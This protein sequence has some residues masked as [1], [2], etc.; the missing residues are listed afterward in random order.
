MVVS[1][2][3]CIRANN[4][5]SQPMTDI[6]AGTRIFASWSA[7]R[8]PNAIISFNPTIA[9]IPDSSPSSSRVRSNPIL[10]S[11]SIWATFRS[12]SS[13]A[14]LIT[15]FPFNPA[16]S[17]SFKNPSTRLERC[18]WRAVRGGAIYATFRCPSSKRC[19]AMIR[20]SFELSSST[21]ST[22]IF[23]FWLFT[24]ATGIFCASS[25]TSSMKQ[26]LG[27]QV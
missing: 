6:S 5:L 21:A 19:L 10:Y 26:W 20:P 12:S 8:I 9:V 11:E 15:T 27:L 13:F 4:V 14:A 7:S 1:S 22:S 2:T 18:F 23:S 24:T 17:Y 25:F 3:L 16:F